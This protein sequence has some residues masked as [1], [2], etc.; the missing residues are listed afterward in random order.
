MINVDEQQ[1]LLQNIAKKLKRNI[2]VY[3][4][5]G[6]AMMFHGIK[7][8]TKDIDLVFDNEKDMK[9]FEDAAFALEIDEVSQPILTQFG[10]HLIKRTG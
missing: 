3:A 5:G 10:W 9:E 8:T 6:T 2:T 7:D 1:D 4:V